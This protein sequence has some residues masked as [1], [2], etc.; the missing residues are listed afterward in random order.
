MS[1][2]G[3]IN[4]DGVSD[5][6]TKEAL[7][8][9]SKIPAPI[10]SSNY[11]RNIA[12]IMYPMNQQFYEIARE[13]F[14][15]SFPKEFRDDE[16]SEIVRSEFLS[17]ILVLDITKFTRSDHI[18]EGVYE[19]AKKRFLSN[20]PKL[21]DDYFNKQSVGAKKINFFGS[22]AGELFQR[23]NFGTAIV[24][25]KTDNIEDPDNTDLFMC[26]SNNLIKNDSG[27]WVEQKKDKV[28]A[29]FFGYLV[30]RGVIDEKFLLD[31]PVAL[32]KNYHQILSVIKQ[33]RD[34][35]VK[36]ILK[37]PIHKYEPLNNSITRG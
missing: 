11:I 15:T 16:K 30:A 29:Q 8:L 6:A 20:F 14:Q 4:L 25:H 12:E 36:P 26:Y 22:I 13:M 10:I 27:K 9:Q 28:E 1:Y 3:H 17:R 18:E 31:S 24:G 21:G 37:E 5:G 2:I 19:I 23:Y 35:G 34:E 33:L 32:G 7:I